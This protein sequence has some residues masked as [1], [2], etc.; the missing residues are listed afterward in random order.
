[1]YIYVDHFYNK[2]SKFQNWDAFGRNWSN[3]VIL[4]FRSSTVYW[5][6]TTAIEGPCS[7]GIIE[8]PRM[9]DY[10]IAVKDWTRRGDGMRL[11]GLGSSIRQMAL[12]WIESS[13]GYT[14]TEWPGSASNMWLVLQSRSYSYHVQCCQI[15][16]SWVFARSNQKPKLISKSH[17]ELHD[18]IMPN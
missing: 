17:N 18:M 14:L 8:A 4:G 9:R 15:V 13:S 5:W 11:D 6:E 1:M 12:F 10:G 16:W 2:G 7:W 3:R